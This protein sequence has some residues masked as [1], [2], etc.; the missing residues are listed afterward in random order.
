MRQKHA[1][2]DIFFPGGKNAGT[3]HLYGTSPIRMSPCRVVIATTMDK[4]FIDDI[5]DIIDQPIGGG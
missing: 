5:G 3:Q 1:A 4:I 2:G